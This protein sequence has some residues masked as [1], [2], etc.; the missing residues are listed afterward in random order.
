[1]FAQCRCLR[2]AIKDGYVAMAVRRVLI[3]VTN[4]YNRYSAGML[5]NQSGECLVPHL[6]YPT[7]PNPAGSGISPQG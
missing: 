2:L 7:R 1:M 6:P 4:V 5:M 3:A